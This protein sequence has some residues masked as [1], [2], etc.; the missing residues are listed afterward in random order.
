M[1]KSVVSIVAIVI[2]VMLSFTAI[3]EFNP[4]TKGNKGNIVKGIQSRLMEL[5][6][7]SGKADGD[8]GN[9]TENAVKAFQADKGLEETGVVDEATYDALYEGA[10]GLI[11]FR[12]I[13]WYSTKEDVEQLLYS[14]G[15]TSNGLDS[16]DIYRITGP[17]YAN[18]TMGRD[19]VDEGG[20]RTSYKGLSVAGY[21]IEKTRAC[22]VYP[23]VDGEIIRDDSL[24]QFYMAWYP[25]SGYTDIK[26]IYDDLL[27]KLTSLYGEGKLK[28][29]TYYYYTTWED[30]QGNIIRL[31]CHEDNSEGVLIYMA[32]NGETML[33]E[34]KEALKNEAANAEAKE[35]E[36]N[37][38]N[39]SGL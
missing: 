31:L 3:A 10:E 35:R 6:Y 27:T 11:T 25:F 34:M 15:A 13:K 9:G 33:D 24:A 5:G 23:V 21:E 18:V 14:D 28:N 26:G 17:N 39:T 22:F 7:L 36:K 16:N 1:K 29:E 4:I 20:C 8:F 19:R 12:G 37:A 32:A 2:A 38:N 30:V